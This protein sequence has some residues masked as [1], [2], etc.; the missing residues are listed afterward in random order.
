MK[1]APRLRITVLVD[2]FISERGVKRGALP[3]H[4]LGLHVD[5]RGEDGRRYNLMIDGGPLWE[6]LAHNAD[7]LGVSMERLDATV[8]T[9]WSAHH[10]A[11]ILNLAREGKV[12]RLL[13]PPPPKRRAEGQVVLPDLGITLLPL[14]S[15]IYNERVVLLK[16]SSGFAAIV[17]CSAYGVDSVLRE[18]KRFEEVASSTVKALLGGFN[19]STFNT[20]DTRLLLKYVRER[21]AL[22]VPLHSTSI[23]SR[24]R[25]CK[26]TGL[27]EVP[28]VGSRYTLE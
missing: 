18:L 11:A 25:L 23:E 7:A 4:G 12:R 21:N 2:D 14:E 6:I 16:L 3:I 27:D 8:G 15:P 22:L 13:I 1:L 20:H 5:G 19:L 10:I 17:P 28:G 9:I 24:E 26:L